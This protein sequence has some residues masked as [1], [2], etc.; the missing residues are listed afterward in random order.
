MPVMRAWAWG[1]RTKAAARAS[2]PASSRNRPAPPQQALVLPALDP[3]AEPPG[4]HGPPP[5]APAA[6]PHRADDVDVAGA[7]AQVAAQR[8]GD[9][10]VGRIGAAGQQVGGEQQEARGCRSRTAGR[11][12]RGTPAA[13]GPARRPGPASPSTVVTSA[14]STMT[15][16]VRHDRTGSPS[17]STVQAPH[18]PCSQ[19]T[20]VPVSRRSWR[21]RSDS[22]RRAGTRA[23]RADAVH[24]QHHLVDRRG[25]AVGPGTS[26]AR[27]A[28]AGAPGRRP[29]R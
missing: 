21:S 2:C 28:R 8:L 16:N 27:R 3:L 17:T 18:T 25:S 29:A 11:G 23:D 10:V 19:P 20:W 22:S 5:P 6:P 1:L 7:A 13:P 26:A 9:L 15:A 14:P 24:G 12:T 4:G